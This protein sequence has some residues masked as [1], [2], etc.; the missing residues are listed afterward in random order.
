MPRFDY[1]AEA[2]LFPLIRRKFT[3]GPVG[4]KVSAIAP[5]SGKR[6]EVDGGGI[7]QRAVAIHLIISRARQK[8]RRRCW[9]GGDKRAWS[10]GAYITS[11][12]SGAQRGDRSA[13]IT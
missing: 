8:N 4:S 11:A 6:C 5:I 7:E 12:I 3:K 2:E 13:S 1:R 10:N 9:G